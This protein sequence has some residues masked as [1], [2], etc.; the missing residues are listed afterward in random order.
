MRE[1]AGRE[2]RSDSESGNCGRE[3]DLENK[4]KLLGTKFAN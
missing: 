1:Q 3:K 2:R 4:V